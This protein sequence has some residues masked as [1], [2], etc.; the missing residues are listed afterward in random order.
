M[1]II[2]SRNNGNES[3]VAVW[4]I[5]ESE[6]ELL[7]FFPFTPE[8]KLALSKFRNSS[9]R[10]EW[11][12][13]RALIYQITGCIPQVEYNESG[14]PYIIDFDRNISITHT[15]GYAAIATGK[16][17]P[18]ID[19]ERPS[20]RVLRV[21]ER[22]VHL[23]EK[24]YISPDKAIDYYTL[25][26]C[27]KETLFKTIAHQGVIFNEELEVLPFSIENEGMLNAKV[28]VEKD[29]MYQLFYIRCADYFL[30]WHY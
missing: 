26:W 14:Q 30:V 2:F 15:D 6:D 22:F 20:G 18:G 29:V 3:V 8:M 19:I 21:S 16:I 10:L 12:A 27:A 17:Q 1:P 28:S 23:N 5:D 25:I 13:S 7:N 4:K 11:L 24:K 9:R